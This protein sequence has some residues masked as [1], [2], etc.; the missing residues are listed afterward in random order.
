MLHK[1]N[2]D[3]RHHIP[4]TKRRKTNWAEHDAGLQQR[5]CLALSRSARARSK[6]SQMVGLTF[7]MFTSA[8]TGFVVAMAFIRSF[9]VTDGGA[10][11]D[12]VCALLHR[13]PAGILPGPLL[14]PSSRNRKPDLRRNGG[15]CRQ[16]A[17]GAAHGRKLQS[18][19]NH[20]A[21]GLFLCPRR[22]RG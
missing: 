11:R 1:V 9:I 18:S 22:D 15:Y 8:T 6:F 16:P 20:D 7:P 12:P 19:S 14:R 21:L 2:A 4:R 5:S 17:S 3:R 10:R 13:R